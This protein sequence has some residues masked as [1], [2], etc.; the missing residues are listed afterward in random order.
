MERRAKIDAGAYVYFTF[1]RPFAELA[2]VEIDWTVPRDSL[3]LYPFLE[4]IDGSLDA[5]ARHA[6]RDAGDVLLA[7]ARRFREPLAARL[8]RRTATTA[9]RGSCG[10]RCATA[11][12]IAW[13]W[14][15]LVGVPDVDGV[16][17]VR[18]HEVL[19]P[20]QGL[21]IRAD[22]LWAELTCETPREHW[23]F[24]LEAFGVRLDRADDA[25]RPGGEIGERIAVG[26]DIE[27]EV[28]A[29]GPPAGIVHGDVLV[30]RARHEIDGPGLVL[31][32]RRARSRTAVA[33]ATVV[34][35]VFIPTRRRLP[36]APARAHRAGC[37]GRSPSETA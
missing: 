17:V 1:L 37:A 25:L 16:L 19:P 12:R 23:T 10:S 30:G 18:D 13:Y 14:T 32:R 31:R 2:G 9:S 15:Y 11:E 6:G 34:A 33:A 5:A 8:R 24:G 27:W 3:D 20:D 36:R 7:A 22:G 29:G 4:L 21:E 35:D 26:L 28:G